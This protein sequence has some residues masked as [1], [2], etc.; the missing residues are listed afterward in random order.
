MIW[1]AVSELVG[2][3]IGWRNVILFAGGL[4]IAA[5]FYGWHVLDKAAAVALAKEG[6]VS[7]VELVAAQAELQAERRRAT[8]LE[9]ANFQFQRQVQ[10]ASALQTQQAMEL[11]NYASTVDCGV[12][13][14]LF[15]RLR[16]R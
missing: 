14:A 2:K 9:A 5:G 11:D 8:A 16:N 3:T 6:L 12:D 1:K 13:G 10:E 7:K 4:V 15:K